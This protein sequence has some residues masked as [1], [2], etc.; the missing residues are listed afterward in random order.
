[1]LSFRLKSIPIQPLL[2]WIGMLALYLL[3]SAALLDN[4]DARSAY[5]M[6]R[7]LLLRGELTVPA[8]DRLDEMFEKEGRDGEVYS[9]YGFVQPVVQVPLFLLAAW[10]W[11]ANELVA[12]QAAVALGNAFATATA[13]VVLYS[14]AVALFRSQRI[15]VAIAMIYGGATMAWLYATLTYSEP[16]LTLILLLACR[17][18]LAAE[19]RPAAAPKLL[20][21]AGLLTGLA[22]LTKYPAV[23]YVPALLWCAWAISRGA[24]VAL[25]AFVAPLALGVVALAGYNFWRYE[26]IFNTGYHIKELT[27][28]PRPAWYG[29]YTLFFSLGKS[30]FIYAPPLLAAVFFLPQF[31]RENGR[32]GRLVLLL[33]ASSVLFYAVV[34]PWS[35]A[36]SPGPRY[37]LPVLPLA[38]LALGT[39][40]GRWPTLVA[41]QRWGFAASVVSGVAVQ[42]PL[43]TVSYNDT[44]V[45]LQVITG[46]VYAWGFWFFDPDYMPLVWQVRI[47]ASALTRAAGGPS[48]LPSPLPFSVDHPGQPIDQIA[49]WFARL[50]PDSGWFVVAVALALSA[51]VCLVALLRTI[52]KQDRGVVPPS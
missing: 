46:G 39:L 40:L 19:Q 33:C 28:F 52:A 48:L 27:R 42:I 12:T 34:R 37:Q 21:A 9:K 6:T 41:W 11:P 23:I 43:I 8:A 44:L 2:L 14:L 51:T 18:L 32:F 45:L 3:T 10:L 50:P 5:T 22:I 26:D 25:F 36:W 15:A 35:G 38:L 47:L 7:G 20:A 31:A 1:M 29:F 13:L 4:P 16:L 30:I 17:L 24:R 49:C